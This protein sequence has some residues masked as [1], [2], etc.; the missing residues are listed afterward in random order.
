MLPII[1]YW[2]HHRIRKTKYWMGNYDITIKHF[3]IITFNVEIK[4]ALSVITLCSKE[5]MPPRA[6]SYV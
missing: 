6:L 5:Y 3:Q 4:E 2:Q 1:S